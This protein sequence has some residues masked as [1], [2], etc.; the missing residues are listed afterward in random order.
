MIHDPFYVG[1]AL[2]ILVG[3]VIGMPISFVVYALIFASGQASRMEEAWLERERK[4]E[5]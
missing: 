3:V 5:T 2:G 1:M 4:G